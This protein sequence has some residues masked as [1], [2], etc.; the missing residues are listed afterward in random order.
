MDWQ[1]LGMTFGLVFLSE[2]GDKSQL[3]AIALSGS[4]RHPRAIFLGSAAAL[5]VASFL[6]VLVGEGVAQVLPTQVLKGA[7]ALG[8]ACLGLSIL[9]P[10]GR[11]D[12]LI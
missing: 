10:H 6:G 7:A 9:W 2:L 1:L 3:A 12:K 4:C 5:V 8:F 11:D